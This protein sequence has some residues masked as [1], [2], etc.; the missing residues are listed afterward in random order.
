M[1][2]NILGLNKFHYCVISNQH[3]NKFLFIILHFIY[4]NIEIFSDFK[5]Q[6]S[7]SRENGENDHNNNKRKRKNRTRIGPPGKNGPCV[8]KESVKKTRRHPSTS[9][10][11]RKK[12]IPQLMNLAA[13]WIENKKN[14]IIP[15]FIPLALDAN[16]QSFNRAPSPFTVINNDKHIFLKNQITDHCRNNALVF[17]IECTN[18][19][20]KI[21]RQYLKKRIYDHHLHSNPS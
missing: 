6:M 9:S 11:K 1:N 21:M 12:K 3:S 5:K 10:R 18:Q 15:M 14:K 4:D 2:N 19:H 8:A 7:S 13:G 17:Q 16:N 20:S